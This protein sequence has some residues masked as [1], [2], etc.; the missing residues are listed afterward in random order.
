MGAPVTAFGKIYNC[1]VV[2][3]KGSILGIVPKKNMPNY[4]EYYEMRHFTPG[5]EENG[6][7][8][9]LGQTVPFGTKTDFP[10]PRV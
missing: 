5:P 3:Y 6:E 10:L 1:A 9:F 7:I 8:E 2:M 4:S